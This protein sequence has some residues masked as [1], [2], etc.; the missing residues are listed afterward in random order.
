[1]RSVESKRRMERWE[2]KMKHEK[3]RSG[4]EKRLRGM[5]KK[6]KDSRKQHAEKET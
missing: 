1:M 5:G 2:N 3:E 6:K 4:P